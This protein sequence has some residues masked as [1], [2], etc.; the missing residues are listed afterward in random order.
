MN[1]E[2]AYRAWKDRRKDIA[3]DAAFADRVMR[4]VA[5]P[6]RSRPGGSSQG[7]RAGRAFRDP[8]LPLL[9]ELRLR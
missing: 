8:I 7:G 3:V 6:Q 5:M 2:E 1:R 9:L 4:R